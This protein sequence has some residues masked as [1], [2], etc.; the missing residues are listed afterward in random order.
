M[1][2]LREEVSRAETVLFNAS[3][4]WS[5][6]PTLIFLDNNE[7]SSLLASC[8][9][10]WNCYVVLLAR[11]I[12]RPEIEGEEKASV[13]TADEEAVNPNSNKNI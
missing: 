13:V 9:F 11:G 7:R 4:S 3:L 10:S 8:A 6:L 2:E 12:C 1:L 5:A